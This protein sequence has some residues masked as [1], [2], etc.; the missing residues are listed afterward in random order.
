MTLCRYYDGLLVVFCFRSGVKSSMKKV[1]ISQNKRLLPVPP[2]GMESGDGR[3]RRA[4][5][6]HAPLARSVT[7]R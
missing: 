5:A 6:E 3:L 2:G 1:T 4:S 7:Y